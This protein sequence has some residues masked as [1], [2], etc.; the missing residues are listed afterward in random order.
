MWEYPRICSN[1]PQTAIQLV[2]G[3]AETR[4]QGD[5]TQELEQNLLHKPIAARRLLLRVRKLL[6]EL[7]LKKAEKKPTVMIVD[8]DEDVRQLYRINLGKL[9]YNTLD[10]SNGEQA[11]DQ[12]Q[13]SLDRNDPIDVIIL[14]LT[15]PGGM[16]G[17][18]TAQC[19]RSMNTHAKLIVSSSD[20]C[21][22]VMTNYEKYGFQGALEKTFNKNQIQDVLNQVL[23]SYDEPLN[24]D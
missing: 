10:A 23:S 7:Q 20:T 19:L 17:M 14:D 12:Y 11:I 15:I 22:Q 9:G 18:E 24:L 8:D 3:Y 5:A 2:S 4:Q 1:Y 6:D 21:S 13:Q 16:G